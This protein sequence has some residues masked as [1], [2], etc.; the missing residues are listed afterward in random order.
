MTRRHLNSFFATIC[1]AVLAYGCSKSSEPYSNGVNHT[2]GM[3]NSRMWSGS[4]SGYAYGD[5]LEGENHFEWPE[6]F[7]R[8]IADSTFTIANLSGYAIQIG[9]CV[10]TYRSTDSV[11][12]TVMFDSVITGTVYDTVIYYYAH[13]S[14]T[15]SYHNVFGYN[16]TDHQYY[17][18]NTFLHT[19]P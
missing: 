10:L 15:F 5:T 12:Q 14:I 8:T 16:D 2:V 6:M 9:S 1:V 3:T 18:T 11:K 13:D 7:N 19:L 17:Q 4:S